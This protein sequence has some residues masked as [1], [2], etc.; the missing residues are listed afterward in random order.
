MPGS[1]NSLQI[2]VCVDYM[3]VQTAMIGNST[4]QKLQNQVKRNLLQT[5]VQNDH[6]HIKSYDIM[7]DL[8]QDLN[9]G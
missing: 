5:C 9:V 4:T 3:T 1:F 6:P 7:S 8:W 2:N